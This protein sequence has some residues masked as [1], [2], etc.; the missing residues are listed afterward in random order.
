MVFVHQG[1]LKKK[2]NTKHKTSL[3]HAIR[4]SLKTTKDKRQAQHFQVNSRTGNS[5]EVKK[6]KVL[7]FS[8]FIACSEFLEVC[9]F[10][11]LR[12]SLSVSEQKGEMKAGEGKGRSTR[13]S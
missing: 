8:I 1:G 6:K 4:T 13:A 11:H 5:K 3:Q 7:T 10:H 2:Q 9:C 12:C